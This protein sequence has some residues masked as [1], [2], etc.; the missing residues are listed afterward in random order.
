MF[1][2]VES[3]ARILALSTTRALS[4]TETLLT[5]VHVLE[6]PPLDPGHAQVMVQTLVPQ[7]SPFEVDQIVNY[8]GG[9]S[10]FARALVSALEDN[11]QLMEGQKLFREVTASLAAAATESSLLQF[12]E[13]A[14][15]QFAGH[16]AGEFFFKPKA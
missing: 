4:G 14:P 9:N 1:E 13:Y 11:G 12:P 16:E 7:A 2:K 6:L 10:L 3:E 5:Q 15:I 8:A